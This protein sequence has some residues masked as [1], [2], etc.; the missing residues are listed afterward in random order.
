MSSIGKEIAKGVF[1]IAVAKYSGIVIQLLI[2]A[3]LARLISP[4]AFGTIAIAMVILY[5]LSIFSDI[6]LGPAVVQ[7]KQL[8]K[9]HLNSLFSCSLYI[10][11]F[12]A[13]ILF[14]VSSII[15]S[16]Y[17]DYLLE[18]VCQMM[19]IVVFFN[20]LNVVP[21]AL[22][23][24]NKQFRIIALC[25][26]TFQIISGSVAIWGAINGW[27]VFALLVAP[28]V[29]SI[30]AFCVNYYYYPLHF[31]FKISKDA[32]IIVSSYSFYQ[33]LFSFFNYFSRNCNYSVPLGMS[34]CLTVVRQQV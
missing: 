27:G 20:S 3:V 8:T 1:W 17:G 14:C 11:I 32:I 10:G 33:F 6:G 25:T 19:S 23:R 22:M 7:Y 15:S 12:L 21:N 28:I 16:Y 9:Y 26:L 29:T 4:S 34:S 31:V 5:F 13:V 18:K 30:G 24:K 2:T